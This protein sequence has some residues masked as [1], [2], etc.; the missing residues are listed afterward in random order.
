MRGPITPI[1]LY[2]SIRIFDL[3]ANKIKKYRHKSKQ[4][5][6]V[7]KEIDQRCEYNKKIGTEKIGLFM[8]EINK[9]L[10]NENYECNEFKKNASK[11]FDESVDSIMK[12]WEDQIR[13]YKRNEEIL[14]DKIFS[15]DEIIFFN[16]LLD[17]FNE[18]NGKLD[19]NNFI[20]VMTNLESARKIIE[21][22][23]KEE[24]HY[25]KE[26]KSLQDN[27]LG[28]INSHNEIPSKKEKCIIE[29]YKQIY[30]T[31]ISVENI[32]GL[33]EN[34]DMNEMYKKMIISKLDD[35]KF[36]N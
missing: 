3:I 1:T 20:L 13:I 35:M 29:F 15:E 11:L 2:Y 12:L 5:E 28:E 23:E 4:L 34:L 30:G 16:T 36:N 26:L 8:K 7:A 9:Y 18:N 14:K 19:I 10:E 22:Q 25:V 31:K 21:S 27:F 33:L 17:Y 32:V 6:L 24:D